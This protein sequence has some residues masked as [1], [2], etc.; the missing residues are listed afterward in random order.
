MEV[1]VVGLRV[2]GLHHR[3][4]GFGAN[5]ERG[6]GLGCVGEETRANGA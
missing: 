4:S 5:I 1:I 3:R 2:D 6:S